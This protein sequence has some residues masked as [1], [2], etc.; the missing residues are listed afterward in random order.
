MCILAIFIAGCSSTE[1]SDPG[2]QTTKETATEVPQKS[3]PK[4]ETQVN[5]DISFVLAK[6]ADEL[7]A[8]TPGELTKDFSVDKETS[9]WATAEVPK[10]I[11]PEFLEK[12]KEFL[13]S[14]QEPEQIHQALNYY[15][16][17][18]QY[19]A[20]VGPLIT[21]TPQFDEP[22][23]PEP[24]EMNGDGEQEKAPTNALILL[25]ASSSMLLQADGHLK[26]DTAKSA[27]RSFAK[28][29]GQNSKVSLYA[30]GHMGSQSQ[31]DK[32]LSCTTIDEVY[33][34]GEYKQDSFNDSVKKVEARGWTPLAGAIA[35]AAI[36]H[37]DT[38]ED[39]TLY[40]ISDG[41]ETC[42][43]DPVKEAQLFAECSPDRHVNVIGFQVDR[44]AESQLQ[45]VAKAGNGSYLGADTLDEMTQQMTKLWLPSDLDLVGLIYAKPVGWPVTMAITTV[46][47]YAQ[48]VKN[49][50]Q[51]E[52]LRLTGA[53]N[54]LKE[55]ELLD[56]ADAV[57]VQKLIDQ[58]KA[59]YDELI[60]QKEEEKKAMIDSEVERIST[61]IEDYQER[62]RKLKEEQR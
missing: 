55:E 22:L 13:S 10:E 45:A 14:L 56:E 29:M 27:A 40:I 44:K 6:T 12:M 17:S 3:E 36:D 19:E 59:H 51:V 50:I 62:M 16:G 30:Y 8:V 52:D 54:L 4:K 61:M 53:V 7:V 15:L 2:A 1:E 46:S 49:A 33:A 32:E 34:L 9:M 42:G 38:T 57:Q 37:A 60:E 20:L 31:N 39:I 18:A 25:D 21:Y 24:Y 47:D 58:Q 26:M 41:E 5:E 23:L 35:Q 28:A 11:R 48:K 43:G